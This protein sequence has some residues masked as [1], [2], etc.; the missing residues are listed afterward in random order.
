MIALGQVRLRAFPETNAAVILIAN[1]FLPDCYL[2]LIY[3]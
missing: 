3:E 1:L 2:L